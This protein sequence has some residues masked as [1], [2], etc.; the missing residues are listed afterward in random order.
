MVGFE[1]FKLAVFFPSFGLRGIHLLL[2]VFG[3]RILAGCESSD[4]NF[5]FSSASFVAR[6][7]ANL[8]SDLS[9]LRSSLSLPSSLSCDLARRSSRWASSSVLCVR[10]EVLRDSKSISSSAWSPPLRSRLSSS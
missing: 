1:P 2:K 4:I 8:S 3:D 5:L 6:C 9:R 7:S 10:G